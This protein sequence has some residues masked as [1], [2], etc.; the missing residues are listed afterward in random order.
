MLLKWSRDLGKTGFSSHCAACHHL[1]LCFQDRGRWTAMI[2]IMQYCFPHLILCLQ[3]MSGEWWTHHQLWLWLQWTLPKD[4]LRTMK[5]SSCRRSY[6]LVFIFGFVGNLLVVLILIIAKSWRAWLTSTCLTWP[7]LT[8]CS[9]SPC[10]LGS[11]CCRPVGFYEIRCANF[12]Q[13]ISIGY[14]RWNLLHHP[15]DNR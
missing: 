13:N 5:H 1:V 2:G 10:V 7:S 8:C 15:L 4:Q 6:S 11:L 9:S 12:P 14:F 3:Q